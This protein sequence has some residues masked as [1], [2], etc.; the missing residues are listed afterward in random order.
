MPHCK[1][2]CDRLKEQQHDQL[3]QPAVVYFFLN[4]HLQHLHPQSVLCHLFLPRTDV[5]F[6]PDYLFFIGD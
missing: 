3:P 2:I 6:L 4:T 5:D 1:L